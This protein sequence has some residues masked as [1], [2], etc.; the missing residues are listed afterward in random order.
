MCILSPSLNL[1]NGKNMGGAM[2]RIWSVITKFQLI[3]PEHRYYSITF[4][5]IREV[6][7]IER[8]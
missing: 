8:S 5:R 1:Q 6:R 4:P 2:I 3:S 7:L